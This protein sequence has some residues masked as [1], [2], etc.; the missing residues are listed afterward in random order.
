MRV[1][2]CKQCGVAFETDKKGAY[3][4]PS[5]AAQSRRSGVLLPRTC[6]DC[7]STFDGYPKSKRCPSCRAAAN[8]ARD[9]A[10]KRSGP[11]RKLGSIDQCQCC[12]QDYI[13]QSGLQRYCKDCAPTAVR[14]NVRAHKREYMRTYNAEFAQKKD[15]KRSYNKICLVCGKVFDSDTVTVTC[16]QACADARKYVT[17]S[18]ADYKRG[19]R[20]TLP[21]GS[22]GV[23]IYMSQHQQGGNQPMT[24]EQRSF[25]LSEAAN[26]TDRDAYVSDLCLSSIFRDPE[27]AEIPADR[28]EYLGKLWDA[29]HRSMR[30]I[31]QASGLTHR[32]ISQRFYIP[33]RTV[34]DWCR[35][36]RT[37][38]DYVRLMMQQL[39]GMI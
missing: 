6:M 2:A 23:E 20:A 24:D 17:R 22:K 21:P 35:D 14:S 27:D 26:Y 15:E 33:L 29:Y 37:P 25:C 16:S 10:H 5:C 31:C 9:I 36:V 28:V 39:L 3:F 8:R 11:K 30:D 4:C 7:G 19:K 13:V 1:K 34:D 32:A 38:P 12:G 18:R